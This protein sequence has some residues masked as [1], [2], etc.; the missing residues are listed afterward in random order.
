MAYETPEGPNWPEYQ[1]SFMHREIDGPGPVRF[2]FTRIPQ[3]D[4]ESDA[5]LAFQKLV[6]LITDSADFELSEAVKQT[7]YR[8]QVSPEETA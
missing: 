5:D 4:S 7:T 8:A 3:E 6:D 2:N 1:I